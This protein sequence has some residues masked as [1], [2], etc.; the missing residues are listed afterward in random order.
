M[1]GA[2]QTPS[3]ARLIGAVS[4]LAACAAFLVAP[5]GASASSVTCGGKLMLDRNGFAGPHGVDYSVKC[6]EDVQAY[7]IV[8]N[9]KLD[10]FQP[11][12]VVFMPNGQASDTDHFSCE[13][14]IPGPGFGCPGAMTAGN[15]VKGSFSTAPAPCNPGVRAWVVVTTQQVDPTTG[16]SFETS[17]QPFRLQGPNGCTPTGKH[18]RARAHRRHRAHHR[19]H[20]RHRRRS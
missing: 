13:G 3:R 19:A 5:G 7:S 6:S 1:T 4:L 15:H 20:R 11:D 2:G 14:P 16:T 12:P 8:S 18:R 10:Y 9:K 17:S